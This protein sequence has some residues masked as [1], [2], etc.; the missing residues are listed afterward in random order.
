MHNSHAFKY[1]L[2]YSL[3]ELVPSQGAFLTQ[4]NG[5][6]EYS[7][8]EA[9]EHAAVHGLV[10]QWWLLVAVRPARM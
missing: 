1:K 6:A 2:P 3:Q 9:L 10:W 4:D 8:A 7:C 5:T